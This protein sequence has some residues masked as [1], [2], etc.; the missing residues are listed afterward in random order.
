MAIK[1]LIGMIWDADNR[2]QFVFSPPEGKEFQTV[3]AQGK[4]SLKKLGRKFCIGYYNLDEF[5]EYPCPNNKDLT[6]VK[7]TNCW[8]C[9]KRTGF[10][11]CLRC[12][13]YNC[14]TDNEKAKEFCQK[15]HFVY[16]VYFGQDVYK[17]GTAV[18]A[19]NIQRLLEQ[20][21]SYSCLWAKADGLMARRIENHIGKQGVKTQLNWEQK[22][23][24]FIQNQPPEEIF[25]NLQ[26][27]LKSLLNALPNEF[28]QY[29]IEPVMNN[30]YPSGLS[31]VLYQI[32]KSDEVNGEI[33]AIV[34]SIV[35]VKK[36]FSHIAINLKPFFGWLVD[37]DIEDIS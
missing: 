27:K 10:S 17:V 6:D 32:S 30:L 24:L 20:G 33:V 16:L 11:A 8:D 2:P 7:F 3:P 19:R 1:Q 25:A 37:V 4:V 23:G 28:S 18:E 9:Q 22:I 29:L 35:L 14:A 31:N 36:G 21:A 5:R 13:G 26:N 12:S 15:P 34:G